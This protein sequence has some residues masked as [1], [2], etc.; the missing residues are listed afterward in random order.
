MQAALVL[1]LT[2][3]GTVPPHVPG[4]LAA[5]GVYRIKLEVG[6]AHGL[7]GLA[8]AADGGLWT[9]AERAAAAVRIDLDLT[10][11]PPTVRGLERWPV[12]G[13]APGD[14]LEAL[15]ILPDGAMMVGAEGKAAH[16]VRAY[17]LE[18]VGHRLHVRRPALSMRAKQLGV[19]AGA[20]HGTE[21][22][23]AVP[24]LTLLAIEAAGKDA[25]SRWAPLIVLHEGDDAAE[26]AALT[27]DRVRHLRLTTATGK[28]SA[29]D[30]WRD[31]D[32]VRGIAIE[33]H[34]AVTRILGF[35]LG[36]DGA[37]LG[38]PDGPADGSIVPTVLRDLG[39]VLHGSLNLEGL[40]RLPDGHLIAVVDNQYGRLT[41]PDELI[42]FN[43]VPS[44]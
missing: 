28:I 18:P 7:S 30:C 21:G 24:G 35:E 6:K 4:D 33:R 34:F 3:C 32:R 19:H 5:H 44:W 20:N 10:R 9:I 31:G 22:A 11:S 40:V 38:P 8:L 14:E 12:V 13:L 25:V 36:A 15:A 23:C 16:V 42:W 29:L 26:A 43:D 1:A 39:P 41:G 2:A 37:P 17:R 27:P